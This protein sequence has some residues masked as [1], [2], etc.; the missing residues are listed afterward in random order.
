MYFRVQSNYSAAECAQTPTCSHGHVFFQ[1]IRLINPVTRLLGL[2]ALSLMVGCAT[3]TSRLLQKA[4]DYGFIY[5]T[6]TADGFQHLVVRNG[7][8]QRVPTL[9]IYLEGDGTPW[10]YRR[11]IMPD[12]T[13][14]SPLMLKLMSNDKAEAVYVGRPCYNG[15]YD[16][17]DCSNHLWTSAR[18]SSTVVSS[19]SAV[20]YT[21]MDR[22]GAEQVRLFGHSGGGALAMLLA[23]R[24]PQVTDVVTVAGNL[25]VKAWTDHHKYT[26][27]YSSLDPAQ[28]PALRDA[29]TQWHLVGTEDSVVPAA[30]VRDFILQQENAYGVAISKYT[31][32][33]CWTRIWA[34]VLKAVDRKQPGN[35]PGVRFKRPGKDRT[36]GQLLKIV[37]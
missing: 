24:I 36:M 37:E 33:C 29:V 16:D 14:R 18:Y 6:V 4:S 31:H 21:L 8:F 10:R 32:G 30:L 3:P 15:S 27:L 34:D 13:P 35:L 19:M 20:I 28:Q 17:P 2:L 5:E 23:S 9:N 12:P 1:M 25:N 11:I 26:P 7:E 22:Y